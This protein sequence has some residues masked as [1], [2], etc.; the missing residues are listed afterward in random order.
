[1]SKRWQ[2]VVE[3]RVG[4]IA[5]TEDEAYKLAA[6]QW[7]GANHILLEEVAEKPVLVEEPSKWLVDEQED[8][9][10]KPCV[11]CGNML[12]PGYDMCF[13]CR[14][15]M[16]VVGE[17]PGQ[18]LLVKVQDEPCFGCG[19]TVTTCNCAAFPSEPCAAMIKVQQ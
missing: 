19:E 11:G 18:Q 5:D 2:G 3:M 16:I 12:S 14:Q 6:R 17:V 10:C 13:P 7:P 15:E 1:M 9:E 4:V 8:G